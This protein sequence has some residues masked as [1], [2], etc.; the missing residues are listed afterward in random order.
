MKAIQRF[1]RLFQQTLLGAA[2]ALLTVGTARATWFQQTVPGVPGEVYSDRGAV[3]TNWNMYYCVARTG[4]LYAIY[5]SSPGANWAA[6]PLALNCS[7]NS[8]N[9]ACDPVYHWVFYSGTD[10]YIWVLYWTGSGW[11]TSRV[12]SNLTNGR[13]LCVDS[14]YHCLWYL[15]AFEYLWIL[16]FDGSTWVEGKMDGTNPRSAIARA[17]GVDST[18]HIA[19]YATSGNKSLIATYWNGAGWTTS[20]PIETLPGTERYWSLCCQESTH[21]V[22]NWQDNGFTT[23]TKGGYLYWSGSAWTPATCFQDGNLPTSVGDCIVSPNPYSCLFGSSDCRFIGW[24]S[25]ARNWTSCRLDNATMSAGLVPLACGQDGR[26]IL[27]KP[28]YVTSGYNT[29]YVRMLVSDV[30]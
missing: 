11:A 2:L 13:Q 17:C 18:W 30:P 10:G 25:Y 28:N 3:D 4:Y 19:W 27:C 9:I 5:N 7:G 23:S 14:V 12:G 8:N 1:K 6:F 15:D 26:T 22:F 20:G 21:S 24:N 29:G 16:Y